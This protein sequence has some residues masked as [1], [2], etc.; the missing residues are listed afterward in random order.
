MKSEIIFEYCSS[1]RGRWGDVNS[2]QIE[3]LADFANPAAWPFQVV[4]VESKEPDFLDSDEEVE[5]TVN[6]YRISKACFEEIK[7]LI[8]RSTDLLTCPDEIENEVWDGSSDCFRFS[9]DAF[10][11]EISGDSILGSAWGEEDRPA[12]QRSANYKV[13]AVYDQIK[14]ILDAQNISVL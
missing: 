9:C 5:E 8:A 4:C 14:A 12:H 13:K 7:A 1:W 11:K 2:M 10:S 6:S 3:I